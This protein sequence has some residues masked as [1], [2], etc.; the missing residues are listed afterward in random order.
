MIDQ[1]SSLTDMTVSAQQALVRGVLDGNDEVIAT[2]RLYIIRLLIEIAGDSP[3]CRD[4]GAFTKRDIADKT[5][6]YLVCG[7]RPTGG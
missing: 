7:Q 4:Y 1:H 3:L 6:A 2:F 5:F